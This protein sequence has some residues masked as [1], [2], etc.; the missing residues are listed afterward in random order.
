MK[1]N[2][3]CTQNAYKCQDLLGLGRLCQRE[4]LLL[5]DSSHWFHLAGAAKQKTSP[6]TSLAQGTYLGLLRAPE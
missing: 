1:N 3:L 6:H 5:L 4:I 2:V